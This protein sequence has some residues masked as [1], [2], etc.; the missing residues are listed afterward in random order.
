MP[1]LAPPG[2]SRPMEVFWIELSPS[3][4]GLLLKLPQVL[5]VPHGATVLQALLQIG[6]DPDKTK[7]LLA[8]RAVAVFGLVAGL[9]TCLYPGD[10]IEILDELRFDP[11]ESRRRRARH[12][13][14]QPGR[15]TR[16]SGR[17]ISSPEH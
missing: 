3:D 13:Q 7:S 4:P 14:A 6:L 17:G 5:C 1:G 2:L 8:Q 9:D 12:R 10:R 16:K 11:M 15:S